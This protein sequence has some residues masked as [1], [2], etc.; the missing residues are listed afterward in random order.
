MK[1]VDHALRGG[2]ILI[3]EDDAILALD[4]REIFRQAGA[5]VIGPV[6][7]LR[8]ALVM[9]SDVPV[10]AALLDVN[11]RDAEVFP[12]ALALK[13]RGIGMVF[14]TGYA[15]VD[16]LRRDWPGVQVLTKPAPPR[17]LISAMS[18]TCLS[19]SESHLSQMPLPSLAEREIQSSR[20]R[21]RR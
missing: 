7:T 18:E 1:A 4:V 13:E 17:L 6:A 14:Y 12:A 11:L 8:Q 10:S 21:I 19:V 2:R 3:A 20:E 5:E 15:D 16:S 9:I